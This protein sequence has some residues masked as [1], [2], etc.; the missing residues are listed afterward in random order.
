VGCPQSSVKVKP[1]SNPHTLNIIGASCGVERVIT[2]LQ[3][4]TILSYFPASVPRVLS[5]HRRADE[6]VC[7]EAKLSHLDMAAASREWFQERTKGSSQLIKKIKRE[8]AE[9]ETHSDNMVCLPCSEAPSYWPL[10]SSGCT[11]EQE[12][13]SSTRRRMGAKMA[14]RCLPQGC[15]NC[16]SCPICTTRL[17]DYGFYHYFAATA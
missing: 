7:A 9:S 5:A 16:C 8:A 12:F 3:Q 13:L 15:P 17:I 6:Q 1:G 10:V 11:G 4:E 14:R 2:Q